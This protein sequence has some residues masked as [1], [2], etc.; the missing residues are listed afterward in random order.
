MAGIRSKI[1]GTVVAFGVLAGCSEK[2]QEPEPPASRPVKVFT[3]EGSVTSSIRR[4]PGSV[5]SSQRAE[6]SY[7]VS[8]Q[9][10]EILVKEGD[11]VKQGQLLARLD[12][13]DLEIILKDRQAVFDNAESNFKRGK[14][15][16][17]DGNI[18]QLDYDKMEANYRTAS[19]SLSQAKQNVE[20]T[21]LKAPFTG[22]VA[23]RLVQN[24]EEVSS[25]QAIFQLQSVDQLDVIINLPEALVRS[26]RTR[27][28]DLETTRRDVESRAFAQFKG[29]ADVQFPLTVKELATK[30]DAQTRTFKATFT[31]PA[32]TDFIVLPGMTTTVIID[33][34]NFVNNEDVKWVPIRAVQADSG[35]QSIVW[36]LHAGTMTVSSR[37]VS[38]G[39]MA[40]ASIEVRSGLHA[41]EEIVSV[42]APYLAEGMKVT[43]MV[44]TEQAIA[45]DDD[46][47]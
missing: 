29:H 43:R 22:R 9:L 40:G 44:Q 47:T 3:V 5:D 45:R 28:A 14:E 24:F 32:P 27:R 11:L 15:L 33:F 6:L 41:G 20:Y 25:K 4:F 8:G 35:L 46:P 13:T 21:K 10:Q 18:S 31:M 16:I 36:V 30:A 7:R 23:Q 1:I 19:A 26:L 2:V 34:T 38:I 12:P 37:E 17:A 42:G 39:R